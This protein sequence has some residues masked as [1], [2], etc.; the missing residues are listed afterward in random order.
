MPYLIIG[1][2]LLVGCLF[3][4]RWYVSA[5]PSTL[6]KVLKWTLIG[7]AITIVAFSLIAGAKLWALW[8]LPAL[9]PWIMRARAAGRMAKNW[10]RMSEKQTNSGSSS[11]QTSEVETDFLQ[12]YLDHQS[13]EMNGEVMQG[14]LKGHTLRNL[15]LDDLIVLLGEAK[16]D[17]QSVQ[18]LTAYLDRYF[19]DEWQSK[20]GTEQNDNVNYSMTVEQASKILDLEI[21]AS[22]DEIKQAHHRLMN[23]NHPDHGGSTYLATQINQAK[24]FLLGD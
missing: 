12:M 5:P 11:D 17:K 20:A 7:L 14:S 24:D 2:A 10:A 18:V 16:D 22:E 6:F 19:S 4:V 15:S 9:L 21:G 1:V 13:G 3:I 23:K 8:A